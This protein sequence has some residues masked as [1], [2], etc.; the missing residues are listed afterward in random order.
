MKYN[1][2]PRHL[3]LFGDLRSNVDLVFRV[4]VE[5]DTRSSGIGEQEATPISETG[6]V[7]VELNGTYKFSD[8]FRGQG[9]IRVENNRNELTEKTRKLRELRMSGTL[10]FR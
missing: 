8:N 2:R 7:K 9:V 1:L 4:E 5:S 3:P 10:F 6:R